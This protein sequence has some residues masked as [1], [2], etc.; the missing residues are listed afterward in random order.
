MSIQNEEYHV[1]NENKS[2]EIDI[3]IQLLNT[4]FY[5]KTTLFHT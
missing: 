4:G 3:L 2:P 5:F 1:L